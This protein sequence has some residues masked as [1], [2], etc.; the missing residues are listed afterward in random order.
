MLQGLVLVRTAIYMRN[1]FTSAHCNIELVSDATVFRGAEDETCGGKSPDFPKKPAAKKVFHKSTA[2]LLAGAKQE[3]LTQA[4]NNDVTQI[5]PCEAYQSRFS[6][7]KHGIWSSRM[8]G[9][10][11]M[12]FFPFPLTWENRVSILSRDQGSPN[13][14]FPTKSANQDRLRGKESVIRK[15]FQHPN[16][17]RSVDIRS[18]PKK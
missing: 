3:I 17:T 9:H 18:R 10:C 15:K 8:H 14:I 7:R 4:C 2:P 12:K 5:R 16:T 13:A 1:V 6:R 11:Y